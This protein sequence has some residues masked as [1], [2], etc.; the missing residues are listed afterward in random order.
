MPSFS[1]NIFMRK[2]WRW[3][4]IKELA[5]D[6]VVF[7]DFMH[8]VFLYF[9]ARIIFYVMACIWRAIIP[10]LYPKIAFDRTSWF[11][12]LKITNNCITN[13]A[14]ERILRIWTKRQQW[15]HKSMKWTHN[16]LTNFRHSPARIHNL[17][18]DIAIEH[19]SHVCDLNNDWNI[20]TC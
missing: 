3:I 8:I 2:R 5:A 11:L 1:F 17:D 6:L 9:I 7:H 14:F 18:L 10:R 4:A 20:S 19:S 15:N 16:K 13:I 12:C